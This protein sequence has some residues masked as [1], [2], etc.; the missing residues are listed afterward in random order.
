MAPGRPGLS[1]ARS[2]A[3]AGIPFQRGG[4]RIGLDLSILVALDRRRARFRSNVART[5]MEK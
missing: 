2:A 3:Q 1:V 4:G 5:F